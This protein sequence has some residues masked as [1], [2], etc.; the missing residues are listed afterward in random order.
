M[1]RIY[2]SIIALGLVLIIGCAQPGSNDASNSTDADELLAKAEALA[3][4][5][6]MRLNAIEMVYRNIPEVH[7]YS[8]PATLTPES[9][10]VKVYRRISSF[11]VKDVRRTDSVLHPVVYE[12]D[13]KYDVF[14]TLYRNNRISNAL[15]LCENDSQFKFQYGDVFEH[16][17]FCDADGELVGETSLILPRPTFFYESIFQASVDSPN[18]PKK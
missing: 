2:S 8:S 10:W 9:G 17:Y 1:K 13:F 14:G 15:E 16:T 4:G 18:H 3:Q 12:V 5:E 7:R 11:E 6:L